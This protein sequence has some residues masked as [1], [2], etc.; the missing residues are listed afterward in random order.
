VV[1]TNEVF[2]GGRTDG[3]GY[4]EDDPTAPRNPYGS[5][6]LAGELAAR[7][8]FDGHAGLWIVRTSWL[9]GSPGMA[10]PEKVVAAADRLS[11]GEPLPV[12]ADEVGCPT[13]TVDLA[14][15]VL[16]L[17][18][19][20]HGGTYHLAGRGPA[21]RLEW[22]TAVLKVC[23]PDRALVPISRSAYLRPSDAPPWA[24]LDTR[25]AQAAGISMR[26]WD[27]ALRAYLATTDLR[28]STPGA[29]RG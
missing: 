10:F 27:A 15:A 22:A 4:L 18:G 23:R 16:A 7:E 11:A 19:A 24:V 29:P 26:P 6:K 9:Y 20:T 17:V 25:R 1:S 2:D 28:T 14:A 21:S 12:V 3:M 13:W 8:A 5:S